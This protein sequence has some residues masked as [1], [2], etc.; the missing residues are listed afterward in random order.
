MFKFVQWEPLQLL[1]HPH[2]FLSTVR[3]SGIRYSRFITCI[4]CPN[5]G[6]SHFTKEL[7]FLQW[8]LWTECALLKL[9]LNP[10]TP[11]AMVF[12]HEIFRR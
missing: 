8:M 7:W 11:N 10:Y 1:I 2:Q 12:G 4:L 9:L 6:I 5:P 3:F